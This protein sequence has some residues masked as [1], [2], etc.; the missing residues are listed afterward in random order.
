MLL[1]MVVLG[2]EDGK[3]RDSGRLDAGRTGS[4]GVVGLLIIISCRKGVFA[5]VDRRVGRSVV[6]QAILLQ[7][8]GRKEGRIH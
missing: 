6:G 8:T 3:K 1:L 2:E 4:V 5:W 7:S